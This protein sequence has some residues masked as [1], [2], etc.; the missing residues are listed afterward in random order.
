VFG[1]LFGRKTMSASTL[2]KG[3]SALKKG[4]SVLKERNDVKNTEAL[5]ADVQQDMEQLN[6][7]LQN[8]I[9][10][11][12]ENMDID[13]F[14]IQTISLKPRRSDISIEDFALLWER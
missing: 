11:I 14:E 1:A 9:D 5:I 10:R 3:A 8:E 6:F 13:N 7:E 12:R 4:K 2:S